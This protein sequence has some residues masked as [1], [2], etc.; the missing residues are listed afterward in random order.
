[1]LKDRDLKKR[2]GSARQPN[3][4]VVF[5]AL[6]RIAKPITAYALLDQLRPQGI[7]A[8]PTIYRALDR[9]VEEGRAHRVDSM[10]AF[11]AC[12]RAHH[13]SS[14][15]FAICEDCKG[16]SE[17]VDAELVR[18]VATLARASHFTVH[19]SVV[20]IQGRCAQCR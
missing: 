6:R 7:S 12:D 9:L 10:N 16:V 5:A 15:I 13:G 4:E 3:H 14:A 17:L 20:E 1:M 2:S 18:R 11:V 19:S 8:P